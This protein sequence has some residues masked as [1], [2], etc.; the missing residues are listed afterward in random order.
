M[1]IPA[2]TIRR[3]LER[4]GLRKSAKRFAIL[5]I[6]ASD[7]DWMN[8]EDVAV[9]ASREWPTTERASIFQSLCQ[10]ADAAVV[11]SRIDDD[12]RQLR[13]VSQEL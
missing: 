1:P 12:A 6:L 4:H 7:G 3:L 9:S 2:E 5:T 8:C 10:L 11:E 13:L